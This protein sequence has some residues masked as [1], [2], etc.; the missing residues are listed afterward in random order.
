MRRS[1]DYRRGLFKLKPNIY[2]GG[3]KVGRDD[4]RIEPGINVISTTF[5]LAED[6]RWEGTLTAVSSLTGNRINRFTHLPEDCSDLLIKQKMIRLLCQRVGGCIQ[7]CM[8]MDL[9]IALTIV[10]C[11]M[12]DKLGADYHR[13][14]MNYLKMVQEKDLILSCAMTDMKGDRDKRPS[15]QFDPD[16]YVHITEMRNDGIFVRGAKISITGACYADEIVAIP[17]RALKENEADFAVAFAIP[18]DWENIHLITRPFSAREREAVHSPY[19]DMGTAESIVVFDNAFIPRERVFMCKEWSFGRR[20]A[21][22]FADSHRHSGSGCKPAVS[23]ILCGAAA[24]VAE[25][26]NIDQASHVKEKL[27]EFA[28]NAE[29]SYA[30]GIAAA[31]HGK[32]VPPGI[33]LPNPIYSNVGKRFMGQAI[34]HQ[35]N[36]LAE[37]AGGLAVTL[38]YEEDFYNQQTRSWLE[39]YIIRNPNIPPE[40]SH[41]IWRL[42]ENLL[43]SPMAAWYQVSGVHGGGSPIMETLALNQEYDYEVKK[44]IARYLAG[45]NNELDQSRD[46]RET[47]APGYHAPL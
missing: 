25:A 45:I 5:D 26:N 12:E 31:L 13:R 6:P 34:Y 40:T 30:A 39:K 20:V 10:T 37:I 42:V 47:V 43:S 11:E 46:L 38:P 44:D 21:M 17:T 1:E 23:D 18:A 14:F 28:G 2:I 41:R 36:I 7:R 32:M 15:Q 4:S 3:Q 35:F 8:G 33:F 19:A 16:A 29:L 9:M 27:S 22:L 24:L